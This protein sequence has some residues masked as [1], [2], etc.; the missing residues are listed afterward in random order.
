MPGFI[1]ITIIGDDAGVERM[2][3]R[4]EFVT[5]PIGMEMFFRGMVDPYLR[6]RAQ[7]RF[8]QEGDDVSGPWAPLSPS[9]VMIRS[10]KGYG[11]EHPINVRTSELENYITGTRSQTVQLGAGAEL[12]FPGQ[13]AVGELA[14]KLETAQIGKDY[15]RTVPRPVL[16]VN[17]QDLLAVLTGLASFIQ[18]GSV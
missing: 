18:V 17:D 6:Q 7:T 5:S 10:Q 12:T 2:L 16:G 13:V 8:D 14:Q 4:L 1:D 15:P 3:Q 9:T 11:G